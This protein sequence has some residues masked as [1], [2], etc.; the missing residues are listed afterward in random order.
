MT[1]RIFTIAS[2]LCLVVAGSV[3]NSC[4]KMAAIT[5]PQEGTIYMVQAYS[6]RGQMS[7]LL[8][9][10]VQPVVFGAAYGGQHSPGKDIIVQFALDTAAITAYNQAN[11]TNYIA[12]PT[13]SYT[14]PSFADTIKAGQLSSV[15]LYIN[16]V[17]SSLTQNTNYML[18]ITMKTISSGILDTTLQTAY[19]TINNL[20]NIY[21][22]SYTTVGIRTNYNADGTPAG[23]T[24]AISDTRVLTTLNANTCTI[25]T[26]A[27]LGVYAGTLFEVTVN[28]DNTLTFS[29]YLGAPGA[30]IANNP[31]SVSTY[32]PSTR[33]FNVH[34]MY[35]NTNGTIRKMDEVWTHQ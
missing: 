1:K 20:L 35:T 7:L 13:A 33:S 21:D 28:H 10:T 15:P 9:D 6:T 34:Y 8:E 19:F 31:D 4:N 25:N 30:P 11:G 12:F 26:I 14:I 32:N 2:A 5:I 17:T 18:P 24:S 3:L 16:F 27:N 23:S 29:G 22:G